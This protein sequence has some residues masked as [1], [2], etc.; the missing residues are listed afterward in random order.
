MGEREGRKGQ[1]TIKTKCCNIKNEDVCT[2]V[3]IGYSDTIHTRV[4]V[5]RVVAKRKKKKKTNDEVWRRGP[6]S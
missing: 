2:H 6:F 1:K 5:G 4:D 3:G